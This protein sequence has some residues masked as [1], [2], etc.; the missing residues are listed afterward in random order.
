MIDQVQATIACLEARLA[1]LGDEIL[2]VSEVRDALKR[3]VEIQQPGSPGGL[4]TP[5]DEG[6]PAGDGSRRNGST[7]APA[8]SS[9]TPVTCDGCGREF[10]NRNALGPHKKGCPGTKPAARPNGRVTFLCSRNCG[11][12]FTTRAE[13]DAHEK[14]ASCAP[15]PTRPPTEE[16]RRLRLAGSI[17][18]LGE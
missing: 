17:G 5:V 11:A 6:T 15:K 2:R 13:S 16:E 12:T 10:R 3:F 14:V 7:T 1:E 9:Y 18:G 4:T 8:A